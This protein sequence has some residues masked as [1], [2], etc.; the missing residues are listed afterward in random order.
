[1]TTVGCIRD[2]GVGWGGAMVGLWWGHER[3]YGV[4]LE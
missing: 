3:W 1:M 2:N 4:M